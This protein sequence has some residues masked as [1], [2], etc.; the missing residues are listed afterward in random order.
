MKLQI[1][2]NKS[3]KNKQSK[4]ARGWQNIVEDLEWLLG[5]VEHGYGWCS[6][7]FVDRH[8]KADNAV[9]SNMVVIDIDGD[10]TLARFW[11]TDTARAWC[12]ATYTSASHKEDE[13]RFRALFPL[14]KKLMSSA[15]HRGAYFLIVNRLLTELGIESLKDDCGQKPER[16]WFGNTGA[17]IQ[18]NKE[19]E[20]V[21]EFLLEDIAY[22]ESVNFTASDVT[23]IDIKRC[24]W[25]LKSFLRPSED[26]EYESYYVPVMAACAGVG[27]PLFD[28]WVDWVLRG[29]H[30]E[31]DENTAAFKWRGLG[32]YSGHTTLYSLAKKQDADWVRK[33]PD[34]L[35]FG[36]VGSAVGYTEFDPLPNLDELINNYTGDTMQNQGLEPE[37]LPDVS[38]AKK[39]GR[40][41]KSSDDAA[42]ERE[43]DVEKVKS[44]LHNLRTNELTNSLEYDNTQGEKCILQGNDLDLMTVK[45]SCE[46]GIFIPEQR[47]KAAIQYAAKKNSYCPIRQYLDNCS[48]NVEPHPDWNH[49]G[50]VF[51]GNH[52]KIATTAM[53]RMMVGAVARAY[54]PGCTMSWLPILVGAQGVGKSMFA[55]SLVPND[56]FSEITTPIE[57]LMKEQYR[58]HVAWLLELP[59]IDNYFNVR[60]I[61]NFKNLITTRVDEVRFPYAQLP[62]KLARRFVLIGT[63]NRN[64][65]LVDSTGNRRFVPLEVGQGFEIPWKQLIQER[66][67]LWAAAIAA[68]REHIGYEFSREEIL[69]ISEYILEFGDPDPWVEKVTGYVGDKTEVTAAQVLTSALELDQRSQSR[70]EGRRVADILQ[71]LGWR[72]IVTTKKDELSGKRKSI[73]VWRRPENDPLIEDHILNDF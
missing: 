42:K 18:R 17:T 19:S 48:K 35:R 41:K 72:R 56:L 25:L 2:V 36:A 6:T 53:Q 26:G 33:L 44:I 73:R 66:D 62:S 37:P 57:T 14:G 52:H 61:E 15:E 13:H 55:R 22:E 47:I 54:N 21:P 20:P 70:R 11:S 43:S 30:G 40:P 65:F 24:Q 4:P 68:Y 28:S 29:H 64:Q 7:H 9:G 8:R 12:A 46:N 49:I 34:H 71:S 31:K 63:T 16:L 38:Q 5:W 50:E 45:M 39:K 58:L 59:E 1:A 10:T 67:S 32:N 27:E 60:N 3:C 69:A 51:L 23:D